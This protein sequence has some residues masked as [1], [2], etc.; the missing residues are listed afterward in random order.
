MSAGPVSVKAPQSI[1]QP[2]PRMADLEALHRVS[3]G[4]GEARRLRNTGKIPAVA[5]GK[6]LAAMAVSITPKQI[7][8]ILKGERGQNTVIQLKVGGDGGAAKDL[9]V[10]IRD[11]SFHPVKRTLEHVDF[12]EVKLD[13][14]VDVDVPINMIGKAAG[15]TMG[16]I[17]RQVFRTV[18]VRWVPDRIP[19]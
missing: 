17:L 16:G 2:P 18:P 4:K 1:K 8:S 19:L 6:G 9:L 5:Y 7:V 12:V 3:A 11:Y 13:R 15:V 10:M 14:P